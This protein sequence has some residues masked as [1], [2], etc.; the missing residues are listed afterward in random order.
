MHTANDE[1]SGATVRGY[2]YTYPTAFIKDLLTIFVQNGWARCYGA[3]HYVAPA[4]VA[5]QGSEFTVGEI[6]LTTRPCLVQKGF[7][8]LCRAGIRIP[9]A[10]VFLGGALLLLV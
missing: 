9:L 7:H 10:A 4:H 1:A 6:V 8:R 2:C 5:E 3:E